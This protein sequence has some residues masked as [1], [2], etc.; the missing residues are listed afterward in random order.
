LLKPTRPLELH[1][2]EENRSADCKNTDDDHSHQEVQEN[3]ER[4]ARR[5]GTRRR[6]RDGLRQK[7]LG[8]TAWRD[9]A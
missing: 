5:L 6:W 8:G 2:A 9:P 3:H 4:M 1:L 7:G